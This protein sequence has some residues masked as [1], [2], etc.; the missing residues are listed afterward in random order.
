MT[1]TLH[2][3]PGW[4]TDQVVYIYGKKKG[5]IVDDQIINYILTSIIFHGQTSPTKFDQHDHNQV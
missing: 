2:K 1:I 5:W 4:F 3:S